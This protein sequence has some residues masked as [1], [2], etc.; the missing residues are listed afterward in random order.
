MSNV[1]KRCAHCGE[2][3]AEMLVAY[4]PTAPHPVRLHRECMD[5]WR[6]VQDALFEGPP[7][8]GRV[9]AL[10]HASRTIKRQSK[11]ICGPEPEGSEPQVSERKA[12]PRLQG[13][14]LIECET[15]KAGLVGC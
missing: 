1:A 12:A 10:A 6:A 2:R 7:W 9:P 14:R 8:Y 11:C 4:W 15:Q 3:D 5:I 13:I